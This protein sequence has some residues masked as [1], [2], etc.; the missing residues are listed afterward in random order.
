MSIIE[1]RDLL[2][3]K[4]YAWK[5]T[6][7]KLWMIQNLPLCSRTARIVQ[8][9]H[10]VFSLSFYFFKYCV[11]SSSYVFRCLALH[12]FINISL[13]LPGNFLTKLIQNSPAV[14]IYTFLLFFCTSFFFLCHFPQLLDCVGIDLHCFRKLKCIFF[15]NCVTI[16]FVSSG[17]R[18]GQRVPPEKRKF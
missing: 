5:E 8:F 11:Q 15:V 17:T 16:G 18:K 12:W 7:L 1:I 14:C 9:K 13:L 4:F 3:A 10:I 2:H 6:V